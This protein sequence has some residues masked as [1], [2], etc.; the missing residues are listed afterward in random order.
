MEFYRQ[1]DSSG[2]CQRRIENCLYENLLQKPYHMISV[3][4]LCQQVDIS[5]KSFYNHYPSKDACLCALFHRAVR[6]GALRMMDAIGRK[7]DYV[8]V[9]AAGLAYW[10]E[11]K[12]LLD[13]VVRNDLLPHFL[14]QMIQ[15]VLE[16][17]ITLMKLLNT[18]QMESDMDI[19]SC[20]VSMY[21]T[22][23]LRWH[24]RN[25]D[26]P[27]EEMV[28]KLIRLIYLPLLQIQVSDSKGT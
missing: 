19:L 12:P 24:G 28:Q 9:C 8:Q 6:G 1:L 26:T 7:E 16:D 11:Q 14:S 2:S 27:I 13:M 23:L 15:C 25:F 20:F 17:E 5:R 10:K 22:L 4:G 21:T 18:P 3:A